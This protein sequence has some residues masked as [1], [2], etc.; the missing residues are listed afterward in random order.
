MDKLKD[1]V[2][3]D[4]EQYDSMIRAKMISI[5]L[6]DSLFEKIKQDYNSSTKFQRKVN[7]LNTKMNK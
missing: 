5:K 2:T 3:I 1:L 4:K 6:S 7:K